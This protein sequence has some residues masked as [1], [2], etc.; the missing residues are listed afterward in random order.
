MNKAD[1][2]C[3]PIPP[4]QTPIPEGEWKPSTAACRTCGRRPERDGVWLERAGENWE[5]RPA[6]GVEIDSDDQVVMAI[7]GGAESAEGD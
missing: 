4:P 2:K 1:W 3:V 6:C 7:T 5:C